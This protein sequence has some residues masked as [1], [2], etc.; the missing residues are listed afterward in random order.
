MSPDSLLN[1]V[2]EWL[3]THPVSRVW[4][5]TAVSLACGSWGG[6][7]LSIFGV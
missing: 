5:I 6:E 3:E 1:G 7:I 4:I 2:T